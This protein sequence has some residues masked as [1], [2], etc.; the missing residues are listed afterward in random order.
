M[1][2]TSE[3][4]FSS[5]QHSVGKKTVQVKKRISVAVAAVKTSTDDRGKQVDEVEIEQPVVTMDDVDHLESV[6]QAVRSVSVVGE[7][8]WR[9][10][11]QLHLGASSK[12]DEEVKRRCT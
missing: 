2:A 9:S 5:F 11:Q 10:D 1:L 8:L 6:H 3:V 12:K 4:E 7:V